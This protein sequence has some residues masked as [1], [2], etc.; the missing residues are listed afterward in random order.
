MEKAASSCFNPSLMG[1]KIADSEISIEKL[2]LIK[3]TKVDGTIISASIIQSIY[4]H[5]NSLPEGRQ[6]VKKQKQKTFTQ[7]R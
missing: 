6:K 1:I 5:I 4:T 2:K 7:F 3:D